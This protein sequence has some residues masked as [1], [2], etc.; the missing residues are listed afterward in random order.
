MEPKSKLLYLYTN[1]HFQVWTFDGSFVKKIFIDDSR[2]PLIGSVLDSQYLMTVFW[3]HPGEGGVRSTLVWLGYAGK[4]VREEL[5]Y[6]D[7]MKVNVH[8]WGS[9]THSQ[10]NGI[11]TLQE[12]W[13]G[14]VYA[15]SG[16]GYEPL[17]SLD[18]KEL[19]PSRKELQELPENLYQDYAVLNKVLV[20]AKYLWVTLA[21]KEAKYEMVVDMSEKTLPHSRIYTQKPEYGFG[22]ANP[23]IQ[24]M[25]FLLGYIDV[26]GDAYMLLQPGNLTEVGRKSLGEKCGGGSIDEFNNPVLVRVR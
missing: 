8:L 7:D 15:V 24:G 19:T 22:I 14:T 2:T 25:V 20:S 9:P 17:Y 4:V 26:K 13:S 1:K 11:H 16:K 3:E 12:E 18:L 6:E 5:L 21:H 10:L 23:D